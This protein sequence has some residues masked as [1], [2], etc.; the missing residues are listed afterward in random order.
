MGHGD[1]WRLRSVGRGHFGVIDDE[2]V[3]QAV[4]MNQLESELIVDG[5]FERRPW[6]G[7]VD[8]AVARRR[9]VRLELEIV[10]PG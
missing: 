8:R 4:R 3:D 7:F 10:F 2:I 1:L 9:L 5:G 6:I